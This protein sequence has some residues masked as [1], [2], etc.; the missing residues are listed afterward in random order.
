MRFTFVIPVY[1]YAHFIGRCIESI[2][3]Q[4]ESN[5]EIIII[6]DGST[7]DTADVVRK[8]QR[9][10][11]QTIKYHYQDNAGPSVARNKGIEKSVGEYIWCLDPDDRLINGSIRYMIDGIEKNP[12]KW[13]IFSGYR[14]IRESGKTADQ[15]PSPLSKNPTKNFRSYIK[16]RI[17]G[18]ATGS[19][20]INRKVFKVLDFPEGIHN[21]EDMVLYAHIF[22]MYPAVS[23]PGI[24]LETYRHGESLRNN[25]QRIEETGLKTVDR[26]FDP[27]ILTVDQMRFRKIY[28]ARRNL[29]IFRSYYRKGSYSEMSRYYWAAIKG[30]PLC[31]FQLSYLRKYLKCFFIRNN[32]G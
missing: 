30:Y 2:I 3:Q 5:Y 28:M 6:D 1:N 9:K 8:I 24:I 25:L 15:K 20:I 13:F 11:N 17:K 19:A 22:A 29:S 31:I 32:S 14:S 16:K 18:L 21:N 4:D 23:L 26:L 10:Y 7:D 12:D 27:S